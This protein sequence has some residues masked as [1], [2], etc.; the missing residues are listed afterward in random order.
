MKVQTGT[1]TANRLYD[2]GGK[3][4]CDQLSEYVTKGWEIL[5]SGL[6]GNLWWAIVQKV[7]DQ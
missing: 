3:Q 5:S 7:E 1:I 4:F 2:I 6:D